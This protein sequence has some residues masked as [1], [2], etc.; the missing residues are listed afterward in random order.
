MTIAAPLILLAKPSW[1]LLCGL[2]KRFMPRSLPSRSSTPPLIAQFLSNSLFCWFAGTTAVIAWHVPALFQLG[3]RSPTWHV[4]E[5]ASF[6]CAGLLF[7]RP[8]IRLDK[9]PP[10]WWMPLY[11]F[12]ATLPCDIL[13]AF[14]TF[15]DR[16]VYRS[17][18]SSSPIVCLSSLTDQECAG[19]LM[20]IWVT[21]AYLLP[22]VLITM[23]LLAPGPVP[24][25]GEA[26]REWY[27]PTSAELSGS[28]TEVV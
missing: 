8:I 14:L 4:I 19:A 12:L 22:A 16:V 10:Q 3:L 27:R 24:P 20:W 9:T 13:S 17:Y 2:P 7:W 11:L 6:L 18:A 1:P 21:F 23:Q 26:L 25:E 28:A 5:D 15:C